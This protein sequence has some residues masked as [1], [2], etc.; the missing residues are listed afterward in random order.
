MIAQ[1][2]LLILFFK[3]YPIL[4]SS[5]ILLIGWEQFINFNINKITYYEQYNT[6]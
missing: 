3:M 6:T 1:I 5:Q 4:K 2:S